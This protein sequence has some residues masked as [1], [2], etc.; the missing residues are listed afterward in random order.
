ML[1]PSNRSDSLVPYSLH[2]RSVA[3]KSFPRW[4]GLPA[5]LSNRPAGGLLY[6]YTS[7]SRPSRLSSHVRSSFL[8]SKV[9]ILRSSSADIS[10]SS[11]TRVYKTSLQPSDC[12]WGWKRRDY[13]SLGVLLIGWGRGQM[14]IPNVEQTQGNGEPLSLVHKSIISWMQN[15]PHVWAKFWS[16]E[17]SRCLQDE[18]RGKHK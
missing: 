4:S 12:F 7:A 13:L 3:K 8:L 10:A 18:G 9:T 6:V 2:W 1:F 16:T 17:E 11:C 5:L 15:Q 14:L